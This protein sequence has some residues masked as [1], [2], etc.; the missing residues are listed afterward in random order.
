MIEI[1]MTRKIIKT[2]IGQIAEIEEHHTEVE[3]SMDKIWRKTTLC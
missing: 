2:D 3:A 1:I